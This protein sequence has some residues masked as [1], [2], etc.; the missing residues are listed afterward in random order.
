MAFFETV[1]DYIRREPVRF[2]EIVVSGAVIL[3]GFGLTWVRVEYAELIIG[4]VFSLLGVTA[5]VGEN[6]RSNVFNNESAA[7]LARS[8]FESEVGRFIKDHIEDILPEHQVAHGLLAA[9]PLLARF[10]GAVLTEEIR[11]VLQ[12]EVH[13]VLRTVGLLRGRDIATS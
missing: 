11:A 2:S 13:S 9:A 3:S 6:V 8:D 10:A 7:V 12:R 1:R 4:V 5:A